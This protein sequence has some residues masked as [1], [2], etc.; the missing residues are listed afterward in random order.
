MTDHGELFARA[1]SLLSRLDDVDPRLLSTHARLRAAYAAYRSEPRTS[2]LR[3]ELVDALREALDEDEALRDAL[4]A[5]AASDERANAAIPAASQE[6]PSAVEMADVDTTGFVSDALGDSALTSYAMQPPLAEQASMIPAAARGADEAPPHE[7]TPATGADTA[8]PDPSAE[9]VVASE[10][11]ATVK[12]TPVV[13]AAVD[14]VIDFRRPPSGDA[15]EDGAFSVTFPRG[16]TR[17][18]MTVQLTSTGIDI[19]ADGGQRPLVMKRDGTSERPAVFTVT[20]RTAGPAHLTATL[21][22]QGSIVAQVSF[23]VDVA[24]ATA[25]GSPDEVA[26]IP[27]SS[28]GRALDALQIDSSRFL[29]VSFLGSGDHFRCIVVGDTPL[30]AEL[31]VTRE[32][33]EAA[34]LQVRDV[35][36]QLSHDAEYQGSIRIGED[37]SRRAL[38]DLAEAG[39]LLFRKLFYL[40]KDNERAAAI[41]DL[42]IAQLGADG[43][44]RRIQFVVDGYGVPWHALY[45]ARELKGEP[46]WDRFLGLRHVIEELVINVPRLPAPIPVEKGLSVALHFDPRIDAEQK[47]PAVQNQRGFWE[48]AQARSASITVKDRVT[49]AALMTSLG[50]RSRYQVIYFLCHAGA[51]KS[52]GG[53][54]LPDASWLRLTE[55]PVTVGELTVNADTNSP[56]KQG[57]LVFVNA[58][59]SAELSPQYTVNFP[60]Y[61]LDRGARTVIGTECE[62]ATFFADEFAR[63]FFAA[64]LSGVPVG[65]ALL[66]LRRGMIEQGNPL[67]LAYGLH[68]ASDTHLAPA[69]LTA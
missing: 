21:L 61:F 4:A 5:P 43:S 35:L 11:E 42:L 45:L 2:R 32:E 6:T 25:D 44:S 20:P 49:N 57:P 17:L 1:E 19:D 48:A 69:L 23:A 41:G 55:D 51:G 7:P 29:A 58:C 52:S 24:A 30:E 59:R 37:G 34:V 56:L 12:G 62:I 10:L 50:P 26:L 18:P 66:D 28:I 68:G 65:V 46:Q 33:L 27:G 38:K 53:D 16:K 9:I 40:R 36:L 67:G 63:R 31:D 8:A 14:V 47:I 3:Q 22:S 13:G 15:A 39:A 60:N 64:V 54:P